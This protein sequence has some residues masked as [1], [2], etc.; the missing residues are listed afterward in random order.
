LLRNKKI[1]YFIYIFISISL[2]FLGV[3]GPVKNWHLGGIPI[4][5]MASIKAKSSYG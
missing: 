3:N 5:N 2:S 1:F 4:V